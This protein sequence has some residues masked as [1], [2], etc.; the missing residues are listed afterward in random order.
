MSP[1]DSDTTT[2]IRKL[3]L[4]ES[5]YDACLKNKGKISRVALENRLTQLQKQNDLKDCTIDDIV[6]LC[7][8]KEHEPLTT[9]SKGID[10]LEKNL[11]LIAKQEYPSNSHV[12]AYVGF[13]EPPFL[14]VKFPEPPTPNFLLRD[15]NFMPYRECDLEPQE[16]VDNPDTTPNIRIPEEQPEKVFENYVCD[17]KQQRRTPEV[18]EW[19]RSHPKLVNNL[20]ITISKKTYEWLYFF[21]KGDLQMGKLDM[22]MRIDPQIKAELQQ[23]RFDKPVKAFRGI[24]FDVPKIDLVEKLCMAKHKPGYYYHYKDDRASGSSS[25]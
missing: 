16:K 2:M 11:G 14:H 10:D 23:F 24:H 15:K 17:L 13:P 4:G 18:E 12:K 6:K 25:P 8:L 22:V 3:V 20:R 21:L 9:S 7:D 1:R 5:L 19:M